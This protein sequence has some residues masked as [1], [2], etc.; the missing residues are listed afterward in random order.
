MIKSMR[1]GITTFAVIASLLSSPAQAGY[2]DIVND[3]DNGSASKAA[4]SV[5]QSPEEEARIRA[6]TIPPTL[7]LQPPRYWSD[8]QFISH[9]CTPTWIVFMITVFIYI[10]VLS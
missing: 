5:L 8:D 4:S 6:L 7:A 2:F 1:Y 9:C 3:M 10:H